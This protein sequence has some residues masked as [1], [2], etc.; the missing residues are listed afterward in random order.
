MKI[1]RGAKSGIF[2]YDLTLRIDV[3]NNRP[4][5]EEL[6]PKISALYQKLDDGVAAVF[7]AWEEQEIET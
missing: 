3:K 5:P 4:I 2:E 7:D 6:K 1:T